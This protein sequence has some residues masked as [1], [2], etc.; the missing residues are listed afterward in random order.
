MARVRPLRMLVAA[1]VAAVVC[2]LGAWLYMANIHD[3][4]A[5]VSAILTCVFPI[6]SLA[7]L[8]DFFGSNV[9]YWASLVLGY[10]LWVLLV[11]V[12]FSWFDRRH[13][14]A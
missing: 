8:F 12:A 14:R 13:A 2:A 9:V 10:G 3:Q 1:I 6:A 7:N 4:S 11:Y 5:L